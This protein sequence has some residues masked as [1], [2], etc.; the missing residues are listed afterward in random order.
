MALIPRLCLL[1]FAAFACGE[2]SSYAISGVDYDLTVRG[3]GEQR[4]GGGYAEWRV[5]GRANGIP[6]AKTISDAELRA[7]AMAG[8]LTVKQSALESIKS[9]GSPLDNAMNG[10][11]AIG[12]AAAQ[13]YADRVAPREY[14]LPPTGNKGTTIIGGNAGA[15]ALQT[16]QEI[17]AEMFRA[18]VA[19][20]AYE[21]DKAASLGFASVS[22]Y[23]SFLGQNGSRIRAAAKAGSDDP[24]GDVLAEQNAAKAEREAISALAN[25]EAHR[26]LDLGSPE[27]RIAAAAGTSNVQ[28]SYLNAMGVKTAAQLDASIGEAMKALRARQ[29]A[30]ADFRN[31]VMRVRR[32]R[33]KL[34]GAVQAAA[35]KGDR[36]VVSDYEPMVLVINDAAQLQQSFRSL[37]KAPRPRSSDPAA[38]LALTRNLQ[39]ITG[40]PLPSAV[41]IT[42]A[43]LDDTLAVLDSLETL[44]G[45]DLLY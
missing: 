38:Q 26:V 8:G 31:H 6:F 29:Q 16:A 37:S 40:T 35:A 28:Q 34:L 10:G 27:A 14:Q 25:A 7:G 42:Q 12:V 17:G 43:N 5:E 15:H 24:V 9:M 3:I 36:M 21:R 33:E 18:M 11:R 20:K 30:D 45:M 2:T 41:P 22:K 19:R 1:L 23:K 44:A 4:T 32:M 13:R 39:V